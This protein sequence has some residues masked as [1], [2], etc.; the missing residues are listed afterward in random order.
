VWP[1]KVGVEV[2]IAGAEAFYTGLVADLYRPLKSTN[3]D[4]HRYRDLILRYGQPALELGCGDGDPL[5]DLRAMGLDVDGMDSSPD[6][7]ARL[8]ERADHRDLPVKAWVDTMERMIVPR[9]Y[10]TVFLAGPTFNLLPTD[11]AMRQALG[12]IRGALT[13]GGTAIV[14]LFVP[15]SVTPSV[16]AR[17]TRRETPDGWIGYRVVEVV[18]DD[19][20]RTQTTTLLYEREADG[21]HEQLQRDW[22]LHWIDL[23]ALTAMA[24]QAGLRIV[25]APDSID[26]HAR[27]IVL[28]GT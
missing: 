12:S 6:M 3:F 11:N 8:Q 5:L 10:G 2:D 28:Q 19:V 15:E 27:D 16:I 25:D 7:I 23:T 20:A 22:V 17:V 18:R 26:H 24:T 21:V 4:P 13:E 9:R 14:P 1:T